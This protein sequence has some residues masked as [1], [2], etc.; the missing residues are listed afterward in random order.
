ML[1]KFFKMSENAM[2]LRRINKKAEIATNR[3]GV[4]EFKIGTWK[5][6]IKE[7]MGPGMAA[8]MNVPAMIAANFTKRVFHNL[9]IAHRERINGTV[10]KYGV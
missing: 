7:V 5:S 10:P 9:K 4:V 3:D 1:P 6:L 8:K 2:A